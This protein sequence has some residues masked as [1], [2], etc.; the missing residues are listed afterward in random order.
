MKAHLGVLLSEVVRSLNNPIVPQREP[1][2][3]YNL[4]RHH[5]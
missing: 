4:L 3:V 2:G 5:S 1:S